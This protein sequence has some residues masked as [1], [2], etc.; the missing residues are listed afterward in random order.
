MGVR[1]ESLLRSL[2]AW[3]VDSLS[4]N[5][6]SDQSQVDCWRL[7]LREHAGDL[8]REQPSCMENISKNAS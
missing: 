7:K 4:E 5:P 1:A 3:K 8:L 6:L 2:F